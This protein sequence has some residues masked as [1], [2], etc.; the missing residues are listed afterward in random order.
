MLIASVAPSR[1]S[2]GRRD[3]FSSPFGEMTPSH[4]GCVAAGA[5]AQISKARLL[6]GV[7][8]VTARKTKLERPAV[9]VQLAWSCC[10]VKDG[11]EARSWH[12]RNGDPKGKCRSGGKSR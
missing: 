2:A 3:S 7:A 4:R 1:R 9:A 12:G 11:D 10:G 5:M 8:V 6:G